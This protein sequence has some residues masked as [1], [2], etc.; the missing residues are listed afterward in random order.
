MIQNSQDFSRILNKTYGIPWLSRAGSAIS[1]FPDFPG[2]SLTVGALLIRCANMKWIRWVL[3]K[4][5]SRHDSVHRRTDGQGETSIPPFQLC[6]SGG[7]NNDLICVT[8]P[9]KAKPLNAASPLP[10]FQEETKREDPPPPPQLGS[11]SITDL[12]KSLYEPTTT[13]TTFKFTF[14]CISICKA[15]VCY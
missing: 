1:E 7:Y 8:Q 2:F 11:I 3:L 15:C 6:W 9:Q 13:Y 5:Q 10:P 12:N 4:I 14:Q